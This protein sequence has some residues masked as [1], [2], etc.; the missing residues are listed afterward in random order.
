MKNSKTFENLLELS[1]SFESIPTHPSGR[2]QVVRVVETLGPTAVPLLLRKLSAGTDDESR[3]AEYL[4]SRAGNERAILGLKAL[5]DALPAAAVAPRRDRAL[6]LLAELG[7]PLRAPVRPADAPGLDPRAAEALVDGLVHRSD[8]ALAADR[9]VALVEPVD[10]LPICRR[11]A[12][13]KGALVAP[14]VE[15]L[16]ARDDVWPGAMRALAELRARL[17]PTPHAPSVPS[18]VWT[19]SG[20][21][22]TAI[23]ALGR[24]RQGKPRRALLVQLD[25]DGNLARAVY[26][27]D[28]STGFALAAVRARLAAEGTVLRRTRVGSVS[29]RVAL[30]ARRARTAGERLPRAYFLGRDLVGLDDEHTAPPP[31]AASAS[32]LE[33]G[34]IASRAGDP[35]RA[36]PMLAAFVAV[37]PEDAEA[38]TWLANALMQLGDAAAAL[39]HLRAAARLDPEDPVRHWN[40]SAAARQAGKLGTSYLALG[41]FLR[42]ASFGRAPARRRTALRYRRLYEQMVVSEHPDTRP[43]EMARSEELFEIGCDQLDAGRANDA[44]RAFEAVVAAIPSHHPS[45]SNLGAAYARLGRPGDARRCLERALACRPGYEL[46]EKNLRALEGKPV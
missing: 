35:V 18:R 34:I 6:M 12:A 24:G 43:R 8:A 17:G 30:A 20:P 11:L 28:G 42:R 2:G 19:G 45:W 23:F 10:V 39:G 29:P 27:A 26:D 33:K 16:L 32:L 31:P 22:G 9:L 25:P 41:E 1:R 7:A 5:C 15:E 44:M 3:W 4:L 14:L 38:L 36:R 46:A 13:A 40:V 37:H 21:Y